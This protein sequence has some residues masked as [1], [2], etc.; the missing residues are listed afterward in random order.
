MGCI[1]EKLFVMFA[2]TLDLQ[3]FQIRRKFVKEVVALRKKNTDH[4]K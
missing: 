1:L 4:L 3:R 2:S